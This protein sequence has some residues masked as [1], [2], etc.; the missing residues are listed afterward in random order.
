VAEETTATPSSAGAGAPVIS[1]DIQLVGWRDKRGR[2]GKPA[3]LLR[4][5]QEQALRQSMNAAL[6]VAKELTPTGERP[7]G[8]GTEPHMKDQ[9]KVTFDFLAQAASLANESKHATF[10]FKGT[11]PHPIPGPEGGTGKMLRFMWNGEVTFRR[12]VNHP[13]TKANDIPT[14][15]MRS[16]SGRLESELQKAAVL[17]QTAIAEA[18]T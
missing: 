2:F 10:L 5:A 11:D 9:W 1:V 4:A 8:E 7:F 18:F 15:L 17:A 14:K 6:G 12:S 3:E 13:G 16:L